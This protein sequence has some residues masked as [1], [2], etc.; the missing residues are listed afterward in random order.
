LHHQLEDGTVEEH[1]I[2]A[3]ETNPTGCT[4]GHNCDGH[5]A[6][7]VHSPNCGHETVPHDDHVD[8][9]VDGHLHHP[10]GDHCDD[11]GQLDVK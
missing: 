6:N 7:H 4:A 2:G 5:D 10:H 8:Y 3:S 1:T 11:H 9:L